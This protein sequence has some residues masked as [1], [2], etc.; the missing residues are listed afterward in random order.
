MAAESQRVGFAA[1][2]NFGA[3][4]RFGFRFG[5]YNAEDPR[6]G[7]VA[8]SICSL[9]AARPDIVITTTNHHHCCTVHPAL[10]SSPPC[11]YIPTSAEGPPVSIAQHLVHPDRWLLALQAL[12]RRQA[13][14]SCDSA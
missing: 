5:D 13:D 11:I 12:A 6:C 3:I 14:L 7:R 10:C 2:P 9:L 8:Q 1:K 4:G